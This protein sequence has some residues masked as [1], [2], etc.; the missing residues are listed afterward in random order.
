VQRFEGGCMPTTLSTELFF[1][2]AAELAARVR[3]R[4]LSR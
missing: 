2:P 1:A 4:E 3:A